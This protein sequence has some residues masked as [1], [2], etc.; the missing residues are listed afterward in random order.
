MDAKINI[1]IDNNVKLNLES[2]AYS[3]NLSLSEYV[4]QFLTDHVSEECFVHDR[5]NSEN[6]AHLG[7]LVINV[8]SEN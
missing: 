4:R 8:N 3:C 1:R 7:T 5:E 2:L 6:V